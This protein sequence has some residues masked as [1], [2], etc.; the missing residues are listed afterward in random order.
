MGQFLDHDMTFDTGSTLGVPTKPESATN[1][2]TPAFDLDSVYGRIL[3][4][5]GLA[6]RTHLSA[7]AL[8]H[9]ILN[10]ERKSSS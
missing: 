7:Y 9:G 8:E 5:L 4:K 2:R 3:S 10:R 1:A 6:S